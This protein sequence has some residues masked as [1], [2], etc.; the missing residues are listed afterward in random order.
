MFHIIICKYII[1][2]LGMWLFIFFLT[3][4]IFSAFIII[5]LLKRN[6]LKESFCECNCNELRNRIE[7]AC[8][9]IKD[10]MA[11]CRSRL[12]QANERCKNESEIEK[13]NSNKQL[14][15]ILSQKKE[16]QDILSN[17]SMS[18]LVSAN[19]K[20][21]LK[22]LNEIL[23]SKIEILKRIN[24]NLMKHL[25]EE[26]PTPKPSMEDMAKKQNIILHGKYD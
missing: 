22:L 15:N 25:G 23:N 11:R 12:D 13:E 7:R 14:S 9:E 10:D 26:L 1:S 16:V 24:V 6:Q 4:L 3:C 5:Y 2:R 17:I 18:I 8:G 20:V 19:N 21:K